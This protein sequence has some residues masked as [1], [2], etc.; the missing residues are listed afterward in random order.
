MKE[1]M[2]GTWLFV[3]VIAF[4]LLFTGIMCM[5][6]NQSK[7]FAVKSDIITYI[8]NAE[9]DIYESADKLKGGVVDIFKNT[10]YYTTGK[11]PASSLGFKG[12]DRDGNLVNSSKR[13]AIC[14]KKVDSNLETGGCTF[15][16]NV[17]YQLDLPV[18][19]S[20]FTFKV[21]GKTKTLYKHC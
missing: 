20:V 13:A 12:Y 15:E 5:T 7:A 17:F 10:S 6:I 3:I 21:V 4:I 2:S 1:A 19:E 14:I 16:I 9:G 11:C 8:E 18:I